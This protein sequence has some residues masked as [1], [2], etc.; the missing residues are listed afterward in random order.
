MIELFLFTLIL[1]MT[2]FYLTVPLC[3]K[4]QNSRFVDIR[5]DE[6]KAIFFLRDIY[7]IRLVYAKNIFS[8]MDKIEDE[9]IKSELY[10]LLNFIVSHDYPL[11]PENLQSTSL[12]ENYIEK[13]SRE[14]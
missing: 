14:S 12:Y 4:E 1:I 2:F 11:F 13:S 6:L 3:R 10:E 9:A 8:Q 7:L 5:S